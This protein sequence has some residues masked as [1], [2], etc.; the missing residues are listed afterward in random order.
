MQTVSGE[1]F[2]A[3]VRDHILEPLEMR[4]STMSVTDA[5][6]HG[7]VTG[8]RYWFGFPRSAN[9]PFNRGNLPAGGLMSSA[10]DMAHYLRGGSSTTDATGRSRSSRPRA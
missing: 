9:L 3:Y 1:P 5:K 7:L 4:R 6:Q 2:D 8:Y 10:E